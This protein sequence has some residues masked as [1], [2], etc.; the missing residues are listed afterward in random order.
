MNL[1]TY[2]KGGLFRT[3]M[4]LWRQ[5]RW[6]HPAYNWADFRR[7]FCTHTHTHTHTFIRIV[8]NIFSDST[9]MKKYIRIFRNLVSG[10]GDRLAFLCFIASWKLLNYPNKTS[11]FMA[12]LRGL[13]W[14]KDHRF[15]ATYL[16]QWINL[17]FAMCLCQLDLDAGIWCD[18]SVINLIPR[19]KSVTYTLMLNTTHRSPGRISLMAHSHSQSRSQLILPSITS[20]KTFL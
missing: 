4:T 11:T 20:A 15:A 17:L 18:F 16:C 1:I 12:W 13:N 2:L 14:N 3:V 6:S 7:I 9:D 5:G 10:H 8:G 19:F